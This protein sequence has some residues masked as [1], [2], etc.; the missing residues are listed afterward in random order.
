M[1]NKLN[2]FDR[3]HFTMNKI[4]EKVNFSKEQSIILF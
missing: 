4:L 1:G 2:I 3:K